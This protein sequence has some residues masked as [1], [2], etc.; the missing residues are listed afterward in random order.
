MNFRKSIAMALLALPVAAIASCKFSTYQAD[1]TLHVHGMHIGTERQTLTVHANQYSMV[2]VT[3]ASFMFF[4]DKITEQSKGSLVNNRFLPADYQI[5][6]SKKKQPLNIVFNQ[7]KHEATVTD[8]QK[9]ITLKTSANT[10][11][12]V[13]FPLNLRLDLLSGKKSL[14]YSVVNQ[15]KDHQ[16]VVSQFVFSTMSGKTLKTPLGQ[17]QTVEVSRFDPLQKVTEH[18]WFAPKLNYLMV[19]STVV[20][21]DKVLAK[22]QI[23]SYKPS[24]SCVVK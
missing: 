3:N 12:N 18:Y 2:N 13:T 7:V 21:K 4:K 9:S 16:A 1:Y 14:K 20:Q 24:S 19:K 22:A 8:K 23:M 5:E 11:D 6:D 10:L 17:L 15:N